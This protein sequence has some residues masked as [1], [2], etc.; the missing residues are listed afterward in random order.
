MP[1][2]SSRKICHRYSTPRVLRP[3]SFDTS[4]LRSNLRTSSIAPSPELDVYTGIGENAKKA[5]AASRFPELPAKPS[6]GSNFRLRYY[7]EGPMQSVLIT[8]GAAFIGQNLVHA[9]R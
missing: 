6:R 1:A 7:P 5:R 8:G 4:R 9:W 2:I 3:S